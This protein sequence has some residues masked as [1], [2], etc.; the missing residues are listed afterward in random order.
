MI[1][2][3]FNVGIAINRSNAPH[4][5]HRYTP[6]SGLKEIELGKLLIEAGAG[7]LCRKEALYLVL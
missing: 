5:A 4:N 6:D 2:D 7:E 3:T 1:R